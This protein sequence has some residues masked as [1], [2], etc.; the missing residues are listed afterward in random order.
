M[1]HLPPV[2]LSKGL[3]YAPAQ[4]DLASCAAMLALADSLHKKRLRKKA[5]FLFTTAEESGL[6]GAIHLCNKNSIPKAA[7]VI[8]LETS[9]YLGHVPLGKGVVVRVGD[10]ANIFHNGLT[11]FMTDTAAGMK[12]RDKSSAYQ[13]ALMDGGSCES[14]IYQD[15][16]YVTGALAL[17]LGNY[18][19]RDMAKGKI[20]PEIIAVKDLAGEAKLL[21]ELVKN[22][23]RL[24]AYL[25][26][27]KPS[28][29]LKK[30]PLGEF[31][32]KI[33]DRDVQASARVA[34]TALNRFR[35]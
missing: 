23:T 3:L 13:R 8:G 25:N 15:F 5:M 32:Y 28:V 31:L 7:S 11:R 1:W 21:L 10:K 30:R 24:P 17:P 18:H 16:G 26:T 9:K 22:S 6:N 35:D 27:L 12:K 29:S 14:G 20:A 2:K 34:R 4:D 19:N 33:T